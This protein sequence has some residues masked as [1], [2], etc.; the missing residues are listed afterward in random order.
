MT[1]TY[2]PEAVDDVTRV[3]F[4]TGDT[5]EGE[6]FLSDEEIDMMISEEGSYQKAVIAC[7]QLIIAKL[8]QPN[9]TA[10]WLT[11]DNKSAREGYQTLLAQ[12]RN[13]FG[14]A[15]LSSGVQSVTRSDSAD[16]DDT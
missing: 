2:T 3:R 13:K 9:F 16:D 8:S 4:W 7:L 1:F 14:V 10:D 6:N 5:T 11:V 15:A 12:M